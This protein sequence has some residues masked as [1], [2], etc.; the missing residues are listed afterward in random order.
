VVV[1]SQVGD[2]AGW[3]LVGRGQSGRG[4]GP[5]ARVCSEGGGSSVVCHK[6]I[7]KTAHRLAFV[8]RVGPLLLSST[9]GF[10]EVM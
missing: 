10:T 1:T 6:I 2:V 7:I 4:E 9:S 3:L 5:P 8:A